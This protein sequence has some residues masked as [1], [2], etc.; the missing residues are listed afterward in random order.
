MTFTSLDGWSCKGTVN[1]YQMHYDSKTSTT[2]PVQCSDG[3]TGNVAVAFPTQNRAATRPGDVA[4]SF[5]LSDGTTGQFR[6]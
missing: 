5:K 4:Y 6:V 3:R 1:F 2:F